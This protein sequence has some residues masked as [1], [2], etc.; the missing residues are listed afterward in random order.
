MPLRISLPKLGSLGLARIPPDFFQIRHFLGP[1]G[2]GGRGNV[3]SGRLQGED[4]WRE[5][6]PGRGE[7]A[8]PG[9][10]EGELGGGRGGGGTDRD[11]EGGE[12]ARSLTNAA[13]LERDGGPHEISNKMR[14]EGRRR[15]GL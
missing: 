1:A 8:V 6:G 15:G 14:V 10:R 2:S 9:C 3:M 13:G 5:G 4:W 7:G 11:R 12:G